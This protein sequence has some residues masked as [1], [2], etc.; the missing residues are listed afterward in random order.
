[1]YTIYRNFSSY[2]F[3]GLTRKCETKSNFRTELE[4]L[5]LNSLFT[6]S[7]SLVY[8]LTLLSSEMQR[9]RVTCFSLWVGEGDRELEGYTICTLHSI[10]DMYQW[11]YVAPSQI[12]S[13]VVCSINPHSPVA[14]PDLMAS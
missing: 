12:S 14:S 13:M 5:Y 2:L 10:K 8:H 1:M 3:Y 7:M 9:Q 6:I 11:K 4:L